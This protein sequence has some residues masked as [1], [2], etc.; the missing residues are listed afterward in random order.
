MSCPAGED[1]N[2]GCFQEG[3]AATG[4]ATLSR[5]EKRCCTGFSVLAAVD[6]KKRRAMTTERLCAVTLA[7][8]MRFLALVEL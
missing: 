7:N 3:E 1:A 8:G 6:S 5:Y 2:V 4:I